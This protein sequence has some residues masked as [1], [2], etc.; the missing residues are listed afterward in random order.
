M[1]ATTSLFNFIVMIAVITTLARQLKYLSGVAIIEKHYTT[2]VRTVTNE[3][4]LLKYFIMS[5][6]SCT[7]NQL[8]T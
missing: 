6:Y 2:A 1:V 7:Y 8:G 4:I 5:Y 3:T